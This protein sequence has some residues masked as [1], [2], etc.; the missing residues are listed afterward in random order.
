[1]LTLSSSS[2]LN[3]DLLQGIIE[4]F[5]L[6]TSETAHILLDCLRSYTFLN[7]LKQMGRAEAIHMVKVFIRVK[8]R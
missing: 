8:I 5:V 7:V 6:D 4:V 1:V 3:P 2:T